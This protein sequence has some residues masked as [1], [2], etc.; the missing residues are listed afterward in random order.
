MSAQRE[1]ARGLHTADAAADDGD[2]F[3]L[4]RAAEEVF[5][6]LHRLRIQRAARHTGVVG[7]RLVVADAVIVRHVEAGVVAA[8]AGTDRVLP[9]CISFVTHAGSARNC[10]ATPTASIS[11][12]ATA[13]APTAGSMRPAQ[14]TG[15]S[16]NF[17][18]CLTS[19]DCSFRA[20]RE[21]G[22][23]STTRHKYRCRN[24]PPYLS[25]RWFQLAMVNW[26]SR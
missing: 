24:E 2:F 16:T 26:S 5:F 7:K 1:H 22:A 23:P 9:S 15:I 21:P 13:C 17:L 11:P 20:C 12:A 3:R 6:R 4:V 25:V 18:M 19:K 8:D 10:R 14:T